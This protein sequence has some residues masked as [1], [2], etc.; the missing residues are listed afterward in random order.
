MYESSPLI[1]TLNEHIQIHNLIIDRFTIYSIPK[2][3]EEK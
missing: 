2:T 3:D 1:E